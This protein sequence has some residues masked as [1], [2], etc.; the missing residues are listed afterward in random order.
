MIGPPLSANIETST[1][2]KWPVIAIDADQRY[3]AASPGRKELKDMHAYYNFK[4]KN[5]HLSPL[6]E[7]F[8]IHHKKHMGRTSSKDR[9]SANHAAV[10]GS[11]TFDKRKIY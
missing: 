10:S 8:G 11:E 2:S 1:E 9:H 6:L 5:H 4:T 7:T 3:E